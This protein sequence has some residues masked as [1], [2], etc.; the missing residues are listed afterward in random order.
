MPTGRVIFAS[1]TVERAM[2]FLPRGRDVFRRSPD[3]RTIPQETP[4]GRLD[5]GH[6]GGLFPETAFAGRRPGLMP[7]CGLLKTMSWKRGEVSGERPP[8]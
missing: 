3:K 8:W 2:L 7:P 4:C 6:D 5:E 1:V